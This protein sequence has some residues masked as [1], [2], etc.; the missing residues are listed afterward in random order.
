MPKQQLNSYKD[1]QDF[2][3]NFIAAN[4]ISIDDAPHGAFW[5]TLTYDQFVNGNVPGVAGPVKIL[6]S[7][8]AANSNL[9][10]ILQGPLTVSGHSF[11]RMPVGGPF[12]S[13][14]MIA[15]LADWIDRNCP[16]P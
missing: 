8:S 4:S 2:F 11:P 3:N 13:A 1:V 14:E 12:M 15:T 9:I 5:N 6:V 10:K 7:G 16:N